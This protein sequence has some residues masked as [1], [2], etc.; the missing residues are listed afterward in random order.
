MYYE[1]FLLNIVVQFGLPIVPV[2]CLL[3]QMV[4]IFNFPIILCVYL[5]SIVPYGDYEPTGASEASQ[6]QLG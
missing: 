4:Y 6:H 1:V 3:E 2:H 5:C